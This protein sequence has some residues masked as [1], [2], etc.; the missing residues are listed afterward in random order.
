MTLEGATGATLYRRWDHGSQRHAHG[1]LVVVAYPPRDINQRLR[2]RGDTI[3]NINDS[4]DAFWGEV[5]G[6]PW[7][8]HPACGRSCTAAQ[9]HSNASTQGNGMQFRGDGIGEDGGI[10][11]QPTLNSNLHP[12]WR[13]IGLKEIHNRSLQRRVSLQSAFDEHRVD[14][15]VACP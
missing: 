8:H 10:E 6:R 1:A 5:W 12:T 3:V 15:S 14:P 11:T 7:G 13:P 4:F 2:Q 9:R